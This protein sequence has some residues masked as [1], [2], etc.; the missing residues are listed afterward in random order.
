MIDV[1][2]I[3]ELPM[4]RRPRNNIGDIHS[5]T[6]SSYVHLITKLGPDPRTQ[7]PYFALLFFLVL[8]CPPH[9]S[10]MGDTRIWGP[11]PSCQSSR[12][13]GENLRKTNY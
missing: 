9:T 3:T 1:I 6:L 13:S 12:F 2:R 7:L 5:S 8:P 11:H 4:Q 10:A